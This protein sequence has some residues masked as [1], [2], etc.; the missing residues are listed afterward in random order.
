M[1]VRH[2]SKV[3]E[4][5]EFTVQRLIYEDAKDRYERKRGVVDERTF[6][7]VLVGL[8]RRRRNR[9]AAG[10]GLT[11]LGATS[12]ISPEVLSD[13]ST[14][15][16]LT[17]RGGRLGI[18]DRRLGLALGLLLAEDCL[19]AQLADGE[20]AAQFALGWLE[21]EPGIPL[22]AEIC[23]IAALHALTSED[24][25]DEAAS[26]L[27]DAWARLQ[28]A[29][30]R[31]EHFPAYFPR[32]PTAYFALAERSWAASEFLP[33]HHRLLVTAFLEW[34]GN[35]TL[36]P[37]FVSTFQRWLGF[38]HPAG[39]RALMGGEAHEIEKARARIAGRLGTTLSPGPLSICGLPLEVIEAPGLL[40]LARVALGV[41][42]H[43]PRE[44]FA[45]ALAVGAL[46]DEVMGGPRHYQE[47]AWLIRSSPTP[48]LPSLL[49][50][51]ELLTSE[52]SAVA[53]RTARRL[54]TYVGSE[55]SRSLR[56]P[57]A[58]LFPDESFRWDPCDRL[59]W[60]REDC[61]KCSELAD[62]E[63]WRA[64]TAIAPSAC[65]PSLRVSP[66]LVEALDRLAADWPREERW[67]GSSMT[68]EEGLLEDA[69]PTFC[70]FRPQALAPAIR[71]MALHAERR[72]GTG[73]RS[74]LWGLRGHELILGAAEWASLRV[75]LKTLHDRFPTSDR[76]E[77]QVESEILSMLLQASEP[78][79]QLEL[80]AQ[81]PSDAPDRVAFERTFDRPPRREV[82]SQVL[83][84]GSASAIRRVLWLLA[85]TSARS[86]PTEI[87]G[88][89]T[90]WQHDDMLVRAC[91]LNLI[92]QHPS[93]EWVRSVV[94]G[95]WTAGAAAGPVEAY[96]G[97]RLL[98]ER[99]TWLSVDALKDRV[100]RST[101]A[102]LVEARGGADDYLEFARWFERELE[103]HSSLP[104]TIEIGRDEVCAP[105]GLPRPR[106]L[107]KDEST[108]VLRSRTGA[109]GD[110][111]AATVEDWKRAFDLSGR[112]EEASRR[113]EQAQ[114]AGSAERE[115]NLGLID[116][117]SRRVL[118]RILACSP[119]LRDRWVS[120]AFDDA[121]SARQRV[122][123][124]PGFFQDLCAVLLASDPGLGARLFS[125]LEKTS[126]HLVVDSATGIS[127]LK[128]ALWAAPESSELDDLRLEHIRAAR[129]DLQHSRIA[130]AA[131]WGGAVGALMRLLEGL[132]AAPRALDQARAIVVRSFL[133]SAATPNLL[134]L[135]DGTFLGE[136]ARFSEAWTKSDAFAQHWY[137]RYREAE[138]DELAWA[139]FR[140]LLRCVDKRFWLW[141]VSIDRAAPTSER[142]ERF[143]RAQRNEIVRAVKDN[144]K[145]LE[146]TLV[147]VK[148]LD[149][150]LW[151]WMGWPEVADQS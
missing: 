139:A 82:V 68:A 61:E 126:R 108:P 7:E 66:R 132:Q 46:A 26:G 48:F 69:E 109:W 95:G 21:P 59:P 5:G 115:R 65:D 40:R 53:V 128:L 97:S 58:E 28:N 12:P 96:W 110:A 15:G 87:D 86:G 32:R 57:L 120:I 62:Q 113:L 138:S 47:F 102:D 147:G 67:T 99:A 124:Q 107:P 116:S 117:P 129:S 17:R 24:F 11:P 146:D 91:V 85:C 73:L 34:R 77:Q 114:D 92:R 93:D 22:K 76:V 111:R 134:G 94:D 89:A 145:S 127:S 131:E 71:R 81:R 43:L 56:A 90:L 136:V 29:P 150:S 51:V 23:E 44:D 9:D 84:G 16:V 19:E 4:A 148:V 144:E 2:H 1:A 143:L 45:R 8:A 98:I 63:P 10:S 133:S 52:G 38:V 80:L 88:I 75:A 122:E 36:R 41:I 70:A 13:L 118:E 103:P 78:D 140:L 135:Q 123:D 37:L 27:L 104:V 83:A 50:H 39:E 18:D 101:Y 105:P 151:P 142:R 42:S 112:W 55:E 14:S 121:P 100:S 137:R 31:E 125:R 119:E 79:E 60:R 33:D 25:T 149:S 20:S 64:A 30:G 54:L 35:A 49:P 141:R 6:Q 3:T 72:A 74:L 106:V 130:F